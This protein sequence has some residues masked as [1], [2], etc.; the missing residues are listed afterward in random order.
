MTLALEHPAFA[1]VHIS[2]YQSLNALG[3][4]VVAKVKNPIFGLYIVVPTRIKDNR[5]LP[6]TLEHLI[7]TGSR[8]H[9]ARG[10]L[11][12]LAT[13]CMSNGTN[14]PAWALRAADRW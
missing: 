10:Y 2:T 4:V 14:V 11:D 12:K 13:V 3:N 5:G 7:F 8:C 6:H 9:P 1:P